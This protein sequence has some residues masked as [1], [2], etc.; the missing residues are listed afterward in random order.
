VTRQRGFSILE[1]VV[2]MALVLALAALVFT[3]VD[4][5]AAAF[6][7]QPEAVDMQQ[8]VR[9][10]AAAIYGDLIMAGAGVGQGSRAGP[11][12][13]FFAPVLPYRLRAA[14]DDAPGTFSD[15]AITVMYVPPGAPQTTLATAGP[16]D[17]EGDV[18]VNLDPGC[19]LGDASCGFR[20]GT[21]VVL[22]DGR[23]AH[24]RF[25]VTAVQSN[26]LHLQ[27]VGG[28]LT[29]VGYPPGT[30][31]AELAIAVYSLKTDPLAGS[32]QLVMYNGGTGAEVPVVDHVTALAFTY[33]GDPEPPALNGTPLTNPFGPWTTYGPAPPPAVVESPGGGYPPGENCVFATDAAGAPVPRLAML[34][35]GASGAL[36][37]L[38]AAEL[39][40]GPWCPD[41]SSPNRWDADLLRIRLVRVAVRVESADP[42]L[43][44]PAGVL[45]ARGGTSTRAST[46]LPDRQVAFAVA[47]RNV[48]R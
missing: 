24:D 19:P 34:A 7:S 18:A 8:R 21:T 1:T 20:S 42:S 48:N 23:G 40:D 32:A 15:D 4:S 46:W 2:A 44:G 28:G 17:A 6:G 29:S 26:V 27:R 45:F 5:H 41:P 9:V 38:A 12:D 36:V 39:T 14:Q 3:L 10:A 30:Q 35:G 31:I 11:L 33:E 13:G 43:R 37:P 47:P 25:T 16:G 22:Y